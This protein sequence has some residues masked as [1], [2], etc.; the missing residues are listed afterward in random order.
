[1]NA[2][3]TESQQ[4]PSLGLM[5]GAT[6]ASFSI[7]SAK[8]G[9]M[10]ACRRNYGKLLV[11]LTIVIISLLCLVRANGITT[12]VIA[13][14]SHLKALYHTQPITALVILFAFV[15]SVQLLWYVSSFVA[16]AI[17]IRTFNNLALSFCFLFAATLAASALA[18]VLGRTI[19]KKWL[20][21]KSGRWNLLHVL[22]QESNASSFYTA[23]MVRLLVLPDGM[24]DFAL[25][26]IDNP[27][28]SYFTSAAV[29]S[30]L[31]VSFSCVIGKQF[32]NAEQL[33]DPSNSWEQ[34]NLI[35]KLSLVILVS[36][37]LFNIYFLIVFSRGVMAKLQITDTDKELVTV[38]S[39]SCN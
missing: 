12:K 31:R 21:N 15:L 16:Y 25:A 36:L 35:G 38:K 5:D 4:A 2:S 34:K 39:E 8:D 32:K 24:K 30:L 23:F 19:R 1:M 6:E 17:V 7:I 18:F 22:T 28:V 14:T 11:I 33:F 9:F 3:D 13:W 37:V 10:R 26:I 29:A 27:A 20:L